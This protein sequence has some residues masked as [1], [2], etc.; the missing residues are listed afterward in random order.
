VLDSL[1]RRG[2]DTFVGHP[3]FALAGSANRPA[4]GSRR[5]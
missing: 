2:D 5:P 4:L 3:A 1:F